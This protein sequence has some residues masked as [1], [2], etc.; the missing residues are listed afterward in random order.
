VRVGFSRVLPHDTVLRPNQCG[1]PVVGLNGAVIG[2]N[3]AR[4]GRVETLALPAAVVQRVLAELLAK[5]RRKV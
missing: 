2:I 5:K 4:S 1:G 3:I